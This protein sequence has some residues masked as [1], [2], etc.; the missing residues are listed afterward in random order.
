MKN[1]LLSN[2][3]PQ[4]YRDAIPKAKEAFLISK[5]KTLEPFGL[6][7]RDENLIFFNYF[8]YVS[9]LT[10]GTRFN[11]SLFLSTKHVTYIFL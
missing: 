5:G 8:F 6:N 10:F 7:G 3:S 1:S 4:I 11:F 9:G 2:S